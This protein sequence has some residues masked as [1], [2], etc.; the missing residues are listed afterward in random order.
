MWWYHFKNETNSLLYAVHGRNGEDAKNKI[1]PLNLRSY[2]TGEITEEKPEA[3]VFIAT[4]R[5]L[6]EA[7]PTGDFR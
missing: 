7:E 2:W 6:M 5:E 3:D 1:A 4:V